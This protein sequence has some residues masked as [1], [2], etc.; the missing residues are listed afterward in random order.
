MDIFLSDPNEIPLPPQE[1]RIQELKA[2]P[3]QDGRRVQ[4]YLEI[5]PFQ[6]RPSSEIS[7]TNVNGDELAFISIIES[8]G[9]NMEFT[10]HLRGAELTGP[11]SVSVILFY[12]EDGERA[13]VD[14]AP[15]EPQKRLVVDQ[16]N[17]TFYLQ[18]SVDQN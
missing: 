4:V 10:M 1:V 9:R 3:W 14:D 7:I 11:F 5:T 12:F 16:R 6:K 13:S 2:L 8:I 18:E 17:L 15:P